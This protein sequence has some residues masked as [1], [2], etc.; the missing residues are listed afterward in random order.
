[1]EVIRKTT[2]AQRVLR[3]NEEKRKRLETQHL[4]SSIF[5]RFGRHSALSLTDRRTIGTLDVNKCHR[6]SAGGA[7]IV[8]LREKFLYP[9]AFYSEAVAAWGRAHVRI[10]IYRDRVD[11]SMAL[12]PRVHR[13]GTICHPKQPAIWV[14]TQ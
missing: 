5:G 14:L 4:W 8:R 11:V 12:K 1:M 9:I 13:V 2:P 3:A 6:L 7:T 10:K